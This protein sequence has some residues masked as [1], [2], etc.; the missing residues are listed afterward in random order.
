MEKRAEII[1]DGALFLGGQVE[2]V[3]LLFAQK[4]G[5]VPLIDSLC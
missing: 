1:G 2:D 4:K 5:A 3:A